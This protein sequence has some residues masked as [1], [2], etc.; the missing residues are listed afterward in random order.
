MQAPFTAATADFSFER[1]TGYCMVVLRKILG[2]FAPG[3][4]QGPSFL[5]LVG[6]NA[7]VRIEMQR[8]NVVFIYTREE[9]KEIAGK[10]M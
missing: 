7:S 10:L 8:A 4:H 3:T 2:K 1:K 5:F 6:W 9:M